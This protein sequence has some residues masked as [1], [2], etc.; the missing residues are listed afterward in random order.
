MQGAGGAALEIAA[1]AAL[2]E[3]SELDLHLAF[4]PLRDDAFELFSSMSFRP[5]FVTVAPAAERGW[6]MM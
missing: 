4:A 1:A 3:Q 5:R 2:C 6:W